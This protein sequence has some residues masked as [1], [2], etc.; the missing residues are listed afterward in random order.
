MDYEQNFNL[1]LVPVGYRVVFVWIDF[2]SLAHIYNTNLEFF[3]V[4]LY[5]KS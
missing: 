2:L 4:F 5:F 3:Q 1:K